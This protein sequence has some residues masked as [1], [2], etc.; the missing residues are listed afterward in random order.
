ME[1]AKYFVKK[2][3]VCDACHGEKWVQHPA[4][5]EYFEEH[6]GN[7]NTSLE[8]DRNWF[9]EHGWINAVGY[10]FET[11]TD[12]LPD[13]MIICRSCE[14]EGEI[15]SEVSLLEILPELMKAYELGSL[16]ATA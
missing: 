8:Y 14:G 15:V 1:S 12:G 16:P 10:C 2:V 3:E 13:E 11:D 9:E 6:K 5:V 7:P 4:W